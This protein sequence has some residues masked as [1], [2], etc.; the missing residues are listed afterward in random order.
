MVQGSGSSTVLYSGALDCA[1]KTFQAEGL[2]G[3]FRGL[4]PRVSN[5]HRHWTFSTFTRLSDVH[6]IEKQSTESHRVPLPQLFLVAPA[7]GIFFLVYEFTIAQLR[8]A[9]SQRTAMMRSL[10]YKKPNR[11]QLLA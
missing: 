9:R 7:T 10:G 6:Q 11:C 5:A 2:Q 8:R 4:G 3:L 1:V